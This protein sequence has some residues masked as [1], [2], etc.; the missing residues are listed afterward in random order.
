MT[1]HAPA[2]GS[3][4]GR[5][6]TRG[7][8]RVGSDLPV[9]VHVGD[10]PGPL[11]ARSRDI[12]VGG[13]CI[14]TP[15]SFAL[16]SVR[17]VVIGLSSG[18]ISL[19]AEGRWQF[20]ATGDD[21]V[22]SGLAFT[23]PSPEA[24]ETLS[25]LVL[26]SGR[27]LARFLYAHSELREFG[28]EEVL[29]LAQITRFRDIGAGRTVYRQDTARPG[30]DS[31][32]VVASGGVCIQ[33]RARGAR[34]VTLARLAPGSLFGGMPLVGDAPHPE[35]AVAESD[36][37]LLEID[38]DAYRYLEGSRPW[39]AQRLAF[40]VARGYARRVQEILVRLRDQL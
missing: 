5:Y 40:A 20:D 25:N 10:L 30:E 32:F 1:T 19:E 28:L 2:A 12:G 39:L 9:E 31:V 13:L 4:P 36:C 6:E 35:S 15:S 34:E 7:T 29:G 24:V 11:L 33:A 16:K 17:R 18:P 21:L 23:D 38:R 8:G 26:E 27:A 14:A 37:R 3:A 22:L